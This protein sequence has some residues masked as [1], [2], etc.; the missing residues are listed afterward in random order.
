MFKTNRIPLS[1]E[2]KKIIQISRNKYI[3][4]MLKNAKKMK[5]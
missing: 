4:K 5:I 3:E 2:M 1:D